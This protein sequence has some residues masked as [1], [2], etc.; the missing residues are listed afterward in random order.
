[1]FEPIADLSS[2][3][4]LVSND[5]GI[6]APGIKVLEQVAKGLSSDVWVVAPAVEQSAASHSLTVRRPLRIHR[7]SARRFSTDGTPTDSV[8]LGI[9]HILKDKPPDLVLSGINRG[10]NMADDVT[11]SGTVAAAMEGT[12]LGVPSIALSQQMTNGHPVKWSTAELWAAQIIRR[13]VSVGWPRNVLINVN[14]P[15][16]VH[17]RVSGIEIVCQGKRRVPDEVSERV[18]PHGS[19]YY[20]LGGQRVVDTGDPGTDLDAVSRGKVAVTPLCVDFTSVGAIDR[21]STVF[22]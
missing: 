4:I 11:Y 8:L 14:F 2:A 12:L 13:I 18:D 20:W 6:D 10:C 22:G 21:L 16:I 3:R 17:N 7:L 19:P 15:D 9:R 5:D 1:M